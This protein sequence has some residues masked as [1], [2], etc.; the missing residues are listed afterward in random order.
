MTKAVAVTARRLAER[1]NLIFVGDIE[2]PQR[3]FV[4]GEISAQ[5]RAAIQ[6]SVSQLGRARH[7]FE[8]I[9]LFENGTAPAAPLP[10]N[11]NCGRN[12]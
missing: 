2:Y 8:S 12:S 6:L 10:I 9:T 4:K 7:R 1:I 3:V 11:R 5:F